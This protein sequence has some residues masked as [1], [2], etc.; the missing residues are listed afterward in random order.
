VMK[1]FAEAPRLEH[2]EL[3]KTM[4]FSIKELPGVTGIIQ[5]DDFGDVHHNPVMFIIKSGKV[6]NYQK[7]VE[8]QRKLIQR[9]IRDLL[10]NR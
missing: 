8:E 5:F 10:T 7:Y 3:R 1:V 4:Q 9:R 2:Q 6:L